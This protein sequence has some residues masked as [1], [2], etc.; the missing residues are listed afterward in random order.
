MIKPEKQ[1]IHSPNREPVANMKVLPIMLLAVVCQAYTP[2]TE[3]S[4]VKFRKV[5]DPTYENAPLHGEPDIIHA[6]DILI[7][8]RI[9][10]LSTMVQKSVRDFHA[11]MQ[12][13][14][15]ELTERI[16]RA[17]TKADYGFVRKP[18]LRH[19]YGMLFNHHG[20]VIS[21]LKNMDLFLSIDLP[22][23][24]DIAHVPP[25]FP[26]CD[27][28]A[29][30][31]RSNRNQH[32]YYSYLGF[33]KDNHGPMTELN[34]N[35]SQYL[36]EAVHITVCNQYKHK[37]VKLLERIEIIK[38]NI[39]YKIEKVMPRL[40]P[41]ENA[42]IYGK[43]TQSDSSRQK[44]AIPLGLI[45]SGVSAI[46]GLIMKGVNTW[47][48]YKKS[49]A[50]TKA[51]EKLYEAQE[52]DHRRLT[53]LEGQ[54]SLLAKT[55][56][57]A[58]Q[59]IDYRLLHLDTKLNYTVQHMT[60][61]FRRTEQHF[62]FTWEALVSNR[63]AIHLLSSG[64]AMYDM[65]LRQYLHYY[66]N[67]DVTLDHFLTGLDALG[68]GR[69][70]F[71]VLDPDELDRF[72]SAI[73]RQLREERS[74][75]ELAFNHTYQF[76]AEPMVMFT[77]THDQ[78]LVNVP[79]LLRL[80]TQKPLNLYSID[81]VPMPFDTETLDGRNNE[82]TFINN[83]YPYMALN[84]HNY[85]PLTETQL[86]MCD[87]MGSTYYCQNSY[88]LR[89]RM[90][91]TCESAIYYKM[92]AETITKHCQAKF[93]ANIEFTS[94]VLDAGETM[95]LFNLP[96]PWILLCGQEKQPTEIEFATYKVVD[97]KEFCECSLTAGSFQLDET[98]VKCTPEINSE[99]DGRF[100]SY[101]AINK[102]IF[103][104]L[105]AEKDVQLDSTV[106][107]AL[108]R[109]LDVKP[110]YDWTPLNWYVNPD[111]PDNVINQQPSSVIADLMGV[112]EHIITEGEEEAYQSKIQYRNA[113][114]EFKRFI[115]SAEGWRKLEFISSILGM[116]ALVALI[117]IAIF[118]SRIVESIILGSAVMDE[119]K[120]VNPSAPP[121]CVKA[122]SLPP[123]YPDQINFQPPTLP[124][125]W[126]D[127]GAEGKQKLAAQITAWITTILIIITLLAILYTVFKKCRYV[128]S[129]PWVC[130][131][132]YPFSTILRGT[133][134]MDI[135]V[136]VVN[137]ASAEAMW[138]HFASVAVHP[139]QL[140]ITGYPRA[141]DMHIIKLCCCRQ[142]QIDWQNIVLCDL[143]RNI[144][145]LP[146]LGKISLWS[147]N[148]LESIET[149]IPYQIRVYGRVLDL[150]IPLEIKDDVNITDHRLY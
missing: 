95:V 127:K 6:T 8:E 53:R 115:K 136:E 2:I 51:V 129:L 24:E 103:D 126:G 26:D 3:R 11:Q 32:I 99:A 40:M 39:T 139:S 65:V 21:G 96:R 60:E 87:K 150:V 58:F 73:R 133:A 18:E 100:K 36:A 116:L 68:T 94:K 107:Q 10:T 33:G 147:T 62:R 77:N 84:E 143:D 85:I 70:T 44:R 9:S 122:F 131:P 54:T 138:A 20:Q 56:K 142:L 61:F 46:G 72:L 29:A 74:P 49:K 148:N 75:F 102:I 111:L 4:W 31:H 69:L 128:S 81:T 16:K 66:Q 92:E 50:M 79:I 41:N 144:I 43:E 90:Q 145:K 118:R 119:Y 57:T 22:K 113:Q 82:Y 140:R 110:E 35:T 112:M 106:V 104:Y 25:P 146:A 101:F 91:H 28:W 1:H 149:N 132:L 120:F 45:F 137:L 17:T 86:R 71:Q 125:N 76:Y 13:Y 97:R 141:Y 38:R 55:T 83:S 5:K 88:V 124:Q 7:E 63:L 108:S 134:R 23:V 135:F 42:I 34:S 117:V 15:T 47:S 123:A 30:P 37:Y 19:Q 59:H 48:N 130:F 14:T 80:A 89:Q 64:S 121:A 67:Y 93:A 109:L 78:L 12:K 52:I 27:N 114:S 98:L 105:Q